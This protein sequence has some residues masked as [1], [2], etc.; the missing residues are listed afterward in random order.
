MFMEIHN[1][2]AL[3]KTSE[4][5]SLI[6]LGV[7]SLLLFLVASRGLAIGVIFG[8]ILSIANIRFIKLAAFRLL[9]K[10]EKL[11]WSFWAICLG[12]FYLLAGLLFLGLVVLKMNGLGFMIGF[13]FPLLTI[14]IIGIIF[15]RRA[16][17]TA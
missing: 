1:E 3:I 5:V 14:A 10:G 6:G 8:S 2:Y 12:K 7:L 15:Y 13:C 16:E 4:T 17:R 9:E 11:S